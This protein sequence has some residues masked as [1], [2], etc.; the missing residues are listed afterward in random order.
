MTEN[1]VEIPEGS[2][3]YYRYEYEAG[4]TVYKG[5]VGS[6]PELSEQEFLAMSVQVD[7]KEVARPGEIIREAWPHLLFYESVNLAKF[8]DD[9]LE[10]MAGKLGIGEETHTLIGDPEGDY[11][12]DWT[13]RGQESYLGYVPSEDMFSSGWDMWP[14]GANVAAGVVKF[15]I[16]DD[17]I[18]ILS[19]EVDYMSDMVYGKPV[20]HEYGAY[21]KFHKE[22]P[23]LIDVRLD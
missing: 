2:G 21:P 10:L 20:T 16:V 13:V 11:W 19:S 3:N 5:P 18:K 15:K 17:E 12:E 23:D 22:Y 8:Y 1:I 6:A 4:A 14:D 9:H 7:L